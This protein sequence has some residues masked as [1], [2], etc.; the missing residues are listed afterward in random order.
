MWFWRRNE[1]KIDSRKKDYDEKQKNAENLFN[2][3]YDPMNDEFSLS[4]ML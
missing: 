4:L 2:Q 3:I 1:S